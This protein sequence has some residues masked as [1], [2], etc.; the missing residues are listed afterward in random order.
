MA[1]FDTTLKYINNHTLSAE[2]YRYQQ[3]SSL[4]AILQHNIDCIQH[5]MWEAGCNVYYRRCLT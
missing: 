2:V 4:I 1:L 3:V 5:Q